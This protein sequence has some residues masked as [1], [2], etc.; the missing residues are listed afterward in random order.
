MVV[1]NGSASAFVPD[2][3]VLVIVTK[4]LGNLSIKTSNINHA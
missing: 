3:L 1:H 4:M 2:Q